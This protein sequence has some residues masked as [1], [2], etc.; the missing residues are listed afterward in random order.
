MFVLCLLPVSSLLLGCATSTTELPGSPAEMRLEIDL[1]QRSERTGG[2]GVASRSIQAVLHDRRGKAI[3]NAKIRML[4]NGIPMTFRVG[5]GNYYDR[6]PFY[7]LDDD[8]RLPAPADPVYRFT[9]VWPDGK[10]VEAAT[11]RTPPPLTPAQFDLP[12]AHPR[13]RDLKIAWRGLTGSA[14]LTAHR[15][16]ETVHPDGNRTIEGDGPYGED[17]IRKKIGPGLLRSGKGTITIPAAYFSGGDA[18]AAEAHVIALNV[19]VTARTEGTV[20]K[21][22]LR[23]SYARATWMLERDVDITDPEKSVTNA[24]R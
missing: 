9:L 17:T 2:G 14:E 13:G 15:T 1:E 5:Q 20:A 24:G 3:E 11:I 10:K 21:P 16:T 12:T 4:V 22:F 8:A 6:H 23:G 18:A 19:E 7:R